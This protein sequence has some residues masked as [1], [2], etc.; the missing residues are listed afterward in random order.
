M[1]KLFL[2][3]LILF[4]SFSSFA[5][6]KVGTID[7]DLVLASMTE[8]TQVQKDLESYGADLDKQFNELVTNYQSKVKAFQSAEATVAE[9][10]K[11]TKQEEIIGLEQDIQ[12]FRQNS[13]GLIQLKQNELMQPL[14]EK[15]GKALD[16]VAKEQE[17]TQVLSL[18]SGVA[19]YDQNHDL[20]Q[21]VAD[22]LGIT[23]KQ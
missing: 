11:K 17:Y 13:Q 8:L 16:A 4:I 21:A 5:Q 1:R 18:S 20:T 9:A 22:N 3:L 14:Y 6:T 12:K 2:P 15:V 19:Y 23:L 7:S 10:D